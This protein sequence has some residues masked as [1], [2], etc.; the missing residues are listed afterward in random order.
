[1]DQNNIV[2]IA[3]IQKA[4]KKT[5]NTEKKINSAIENA[6]LIIAQEASINSNYNEELNVLILVGPGNNGSDALVAARL[7]AE[8]GAIVSIFLLK[9]RNDLSKFLKKIEH[10]IK[11][12]EAISKISSIQQQQIMQQSHCIIDGLYGIGWDLDRKESKLNKIGEQLIKKVNNNK[13][14]ILSIDIPSGINANTGQAAKNTIFAD[15]TVTFGALKIGMTQEP[16]LSHAGNIIV[17]NLGIDKNIEKNTAKI[18]SLDK[19]IIKPLIRK[20]ASHKGN[21][22]K[23]LII[24]GSRQY[25]GAA[26]L[27]CESALIAGTGL[28]KL[29]ST[30]FVQQT[31]VIK[32]PE[33]T[34]SH[35]QN[36]EYLN[37]DSYEE[38]VENINNFDAIILGPGI[39]Q[40]KSTID[41]VTKII[42]FLRKNPSSPPVVIDADGLN[43]LSQIKKWPIKLSKKF[44]LTPHVGEMAG[45]MN[46][47]TKKVNNNRLSISKELAKKTNSIILLK[48][49]GTILT[50]GK[51]ILIS[52]KSVP[53]LATAGTGD[54][55]SGLIGG[56]IAQGIPPMNAA[57]TAIYFHAESGILA[58]K[59]IGEIS[60]K[61]SDLFRYLPLAINQITE[62]NNKKIL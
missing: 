34:H 8:W 15:I 16:A 49:S 42:D 52:N 12:I 19:S 35:T 47:S 50:N 17:E 31:T 7:L 21:F 26:I 30:K 1:M 4:E 20:K 62:N 29:F 10:K 41:L 60:S 59:D 58:Q 61:A 3:E 9:E 14:F 36:G 53:A 55:L 13:K 24:A 40:N 37:M 51:E 54:I 2:T 44:I 11:F 23:L 57:S 38:F 43:I 48:G 5:F 33:I 45:L 28:I 27:T 32:L 56:F 22:G 25:P 6:G 46:I 39:T 18:I